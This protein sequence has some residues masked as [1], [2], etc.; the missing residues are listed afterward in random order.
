MLFSQSLQLCVFIRAKT[1]F[2]HLPCATTANEW[3]W[4]CIGWPDSVP[5]LPWSNKTSSIVD[6]CL[7]FSKCTQGVN[8]EKKNVLTSN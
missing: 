8:C 3:P 5:K 2:Y 1:I 7:I 4:R 6:F